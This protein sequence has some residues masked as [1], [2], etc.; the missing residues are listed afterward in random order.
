VVWIGGTLVEVAPDSITVREAF[1]SVVRLQRLGQGATTF[2]EV[3]GT[4]WAEVPDG[5]SIEAGRAACV[6]TLLNGPT[7]LALRVFLGASCGPA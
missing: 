2:F 3:S 5:A 1:G 7:L 4:D 6:E